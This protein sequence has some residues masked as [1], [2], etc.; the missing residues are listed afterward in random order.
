[1]KDEDSQLYSVPLGSTFILNQEVTVQPDQT[2]VYLQNG[3]IEPVKNIDFYMPHCKF[4]LYTISERARV[5]KPDS[6]VV[7]RI[8]DQI[9]DVSIGRPSYAGLVIARDTGP[10]HLT[11]STT[12][13][14][15]SKIQPDVFRMNCKQWD[16]PALGKYL[17]IN[18]MRQAIGDYFTLKLAD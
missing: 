11:Y 12:M 13:Y 2:S 6:F 16:E 18:E 3:K 5:V 10:V 8:V 14:L 1:M 9:E 7:V 4:E 15:E 17:S